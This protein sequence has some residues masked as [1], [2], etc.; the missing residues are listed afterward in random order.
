[1]IKMQ[2]SL[3]NG[4]SDRRH[5]H[6]IKSSL[7]DNKTTSTTLTRYLCFFNWSSIDCIFSSCSSLFEGDLGV[8]QERESPSPRST[9]PL[10]LELP[11]VNSSN[12]QCP[13]KQKVNMRGS[14]GL[15]YFYNMFENILIST[16]KYS[17]DFGF[18]LI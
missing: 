18:T 4:I 9:L 1:M 17:F 5:N 14:T 8:D 12:R 7:W 10:Y 16:L 2:H 13:S 15:D 3:V 6:W 11:I